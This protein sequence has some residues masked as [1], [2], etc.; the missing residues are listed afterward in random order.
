MESVIKKVEALALLHDKIDPRIVKEKN[1]KLGL[2]NKDGSGVFVGITSKGQVI[3]YEKIITGEG[4][5]TLKPIPGKLFYCGYDVEDL[6][7]GKEKEHR[8][9]FEETIYLLL[10]GE[11]PKKGDLKSFSNELAKRRTLPDEMKKIILNRPRHDDQMCSLHTI[12]SALHLFD[13]DPNSIDLRDVT[14]QCIDLIAK[15]PTIIAY[16]YQKN[17]MKK[18]GLKKLIEPD[19]DL[20]IAE[21]FLYLLS[22]NVP[23]RFTAELFDT[24]LIFHAEHG[25]GNNSTFTTRCV[26]SSGANTYMAICAG[27]GSL[28]GHLHGGANE[29]VV[30]MISD[31]KR[32]IKDWEDDAEIES[33]LEMLLDKKAG[34]RSGKIYGMGHAVYTLS[35]PRAVFLEKRGEELAKMYGRE[36]E[37]SLYRKIAL[38][39]PLLVKNKKAKIVCTNVDFYSGFVYQCMGIPKELFTPIFAM[40]RV[41]GWSAHRIEEIIQGRIIRPSYFSSLKGKLTYSPMSKR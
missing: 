41:S 32:N 35:D 13:K 24:M 6:I 21:N 30:K 1:I 37:F 9:G 28:S 4:E 25:G 3:G 26:S 2:R 11:L 8:F 15:F 5:Q 34:D 16:N 14:R 17:L 22:G 39:A 18:K 12:V 23:D 29:A 31:I 36:K 10:T 40:A 19:N 27:I 33:Y 20:S 7:N 38:I